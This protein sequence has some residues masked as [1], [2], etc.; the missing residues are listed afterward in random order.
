M[1]KRGADF[2]EKQVKTVAPQDKKLSTSLDETCTD[3]RA[4]MNNSADLII[5]FAE[6]AGVKMAVVTCEGMIDKSNLANLIY[7]PL[8]SNPPQGCKDA[9]ELFDS[10][11]GKMFIAEEQKQLYTC[12][13]VASAIMSGFAVL[14]CD[15]VDYALSIGIQGYEHRG[16]EEPSTHINLRASRE[17]FVEVVRTNMSMVRRRLKSPT[18]KTEMIQVGERSNT[19]VCICYLTDRADIR[20]VNDIMDKLK[21]IPLNTI[22]SSEF[23]QAF[24]EQSNSDLFSQIFVTE[25][26][27][28]FA[29]KLY[30]GR[31]VVIVDGT[32]FALIVPGLF[33]EN[34]HTM[35]DYTHRPYFSAFLRMLRFVA[36]ILAVILPGLYVALCNFNPEMLRSSLLLNIYSSI[37]TTAYPVFGECLIMYILYE[38]MREAG[39]RLP[40]SVGHAVSIVGGLVIGEITVSAGLMSA[41][42]VL[43][44]AATGLCSLAVPD[45]YESCMIMRLVFILAGGA[46]GLYGIT[47]V[48]VM[49]MFRL[50][51]KNAY[52]VPYMAPFAPFTLKSVIR[53]TFVR[54]GWRVLSKSDVTVQQ[55]SGKAKSTNAKERTITDEQDKQ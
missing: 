34:F 23:L 11:A 31:I 10:I 4:L 55:L 7:R 32:P 40:K 2:S 51:S 39:L 20:I 52:G 6:T 45:L 18:L 53:D 35:D 9:R 16:V 30:E 33:I 25:R 47:I 38:I 44:I 29:S 50:C 22:L 48:G 41:P 21:N 28:V 49:L 15:G 19:D 26:P 5:K 14:L 54:V 27:D 3:I 42:V 12:S 36:F 46:F 1:K 13:D 17:G 43:I 24:L 8:I 37:Q